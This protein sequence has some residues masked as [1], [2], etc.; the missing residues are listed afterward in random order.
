MF[1]KCS[2]VTKRPAAVARAFLFEREAH[3]RL[4]HRHHRFVEEYLIDLHPRLAAL[5]AGWPPKSADGQARK[6]LRCPEIVAA[7]ADAMAARAARTDIT[8]DR[9]LQEYARLAFADMRELA[10]W[11][12]DG[13]RLREAD[14]LTDDAAAAIAQLVAK[15]TADGIV[16]DWR[17]H[18]KQ[19]ALDAIARLVEPRDRQAEAPSL[20]IAVL[21]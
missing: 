13:A 7:L 21:P 9:V 4:R 14:A 10:D 2:I 1:Y 3:L 20:D 16:V 8:A 11:H 6:L 15:E 19:S 17:L 12:P 18:D 5:R